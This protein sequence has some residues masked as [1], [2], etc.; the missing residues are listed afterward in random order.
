MP[1]ILRRSIYR[2]ISMLR[3]STMCRKAC[4]HSLYVPSGSKAAYWY[5]TE[6]GAYLL[7]AKGQ[8]LKT[9]KKYVVRRFFYSF[10][11]MFSLNE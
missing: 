7:M 4:V 5:A 8:A 3:F 6:W 1:T 10:T 2:H 11:R 9:I